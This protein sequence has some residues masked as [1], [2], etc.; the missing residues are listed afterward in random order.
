MGNIINKEW[1]LIKLLVLVDN[2]SEVNEE[3]I[4]DPTLRNPFIWLLFVPIGYISPLLIL[5][6]IVSNTLILFHMSRKKLKIISSVRFFYLFIGASDLL[7]T[8][9]SGLGLQIFMDALYMWTDKTFWLSTY[10]KEYKHSNLEGNQSENNFSVIDIFD[11]IFWCKIF[12]FFS[13][14][15][16]LSS[17]YG[18][19]A[20]SIERFIA[21]YFPYWSLR[22]RSMKLS[23]VL[24]I[25]CIVPP[26]AV[27]LPLN[28]L[29]FSS[30]PDPTWSFTEFSCIEDPANPLYVIDGIWT[31]ILL[32]IVHVVITG[33]LIIAII[34]KIKLASLS[35]RKNLELSKSNTTSS[36]ADRRS[37]ITLVL[38][39]LI[40]I[41]IF[42]SV[43]VF[44]I[45]YVVSATFSEIDMNTALLLGTC[46]RLTSCLMNTPLC[47]NFLVYLAMIP[48]FRR[49]VTHCCLQNENSIATSAKSQ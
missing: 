46:V 10:P 39:A 17:T 22:F 3:V 12:G 28:L 5:F 13:Y 25:I 47:I 48:S 9:S 30:V 14:L 20:F 31:G 27:L 16:L 23:I 21:I 26:W 40:N 8:L 42:G 18:V 2:S 33:I 44:W 35:R 37:S 24:L 11:G 19:A 45:L 38:I 49:S 41:V 34:C 43:G 32:L 7:Y 4:F 1:Y 29:V 15:S 36:Q 6:G